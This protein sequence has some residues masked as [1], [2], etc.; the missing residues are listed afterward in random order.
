MRDWNEFSG[1]KFYWNEDTVD[2]FK[3]IKEYATVDEV[4]NMVKEFVELDCVLEDGETEKELIT[5][6]MNT[7]YD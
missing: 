5:D 1:S 2:H 3:F 4:H 6:L 7:I